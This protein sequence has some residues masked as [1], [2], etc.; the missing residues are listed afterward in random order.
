MIQLKIIVMIIGRFCPEMELFPNLKRVY[1][2]YHIGNEAI[3]LSIQEAHHLTR[4]KV[5]MINECNQAKNIESRQHGEQ[6]TSKIF[7]KPSK[8]LFVYCST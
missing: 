8:N 5:L 3:D 1:Y 4:L 6:S 2:L 7:S